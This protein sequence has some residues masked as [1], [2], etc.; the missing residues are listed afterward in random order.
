MCELERKSIL[1]KYALGVIKDY[2][3]IQAVE[4]F[5]AVTASCVLYWVGKKE[6]L[7]T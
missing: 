7:G 4:Q 6:R 1:G 3:S 2:E 5:C